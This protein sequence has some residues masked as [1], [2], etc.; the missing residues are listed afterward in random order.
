MMEMGFGGFRGV[1]RFGGDSAVGQ[2]IR[3]RMRLDGYSHKRRRFI[4]TNL[5]GAC[6]VPSFRRGCSFSII[7]LKYF[8]VQR[9]LKVESTREEHQIV[10]SKKSRDLEE[11]VEK[12]R[13]N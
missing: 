5:G 11:K 2:T 7:P 6:P 12:K 9:S 1:E 13:F 3:D 8:D 10:L 4:G